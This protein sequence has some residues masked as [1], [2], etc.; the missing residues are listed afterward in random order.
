MIK[1]IT[2][3]MITG[4]VL[5]CAACSVFDSEHGYIRDRSADYKPGESIPPLKTPPGVQPIPSDP[6]YVVPPLKTDNQSIAPIYP[7]GSNLMKAA[8]KKQEVAQK[9]EN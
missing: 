9:E 6:Y 1:N 5:L 2:K 7:P 3:I 8:Q 4:A